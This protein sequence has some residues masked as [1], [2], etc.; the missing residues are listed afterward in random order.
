MSW[1]EKHYTAEIIISLLFLLFACAV[2]AA[3]VLQ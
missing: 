3:A 2:I 1:I